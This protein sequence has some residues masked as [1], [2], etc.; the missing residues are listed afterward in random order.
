VED[1]VTRIDPRTNSV[2]RA[3]SVGS[4]PVALAVGPDAIWVANSGDGTV[5]RLDPATNKVAE[6]IHVG[7][8]PLGVAVANGLVWVT[9]RS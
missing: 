2:V 4:D 1:S 7:H 5:S 8:G 9:V 3:I 6:S